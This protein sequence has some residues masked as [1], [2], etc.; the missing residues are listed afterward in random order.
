M[1]PSKAQAS[2]PCNRLRQETPSQH[3]EIDGACF[4]YA[5][6]HLRKLELQQIRE[7]YWEPN[8]TMLSNRQGRIGAA[9]RR[10]NSQRFHWYLCKGTA[11]LAVTMR[12][13]EVS[14]LGQQKSPWQPLP[15]RRLLSFLHSSTRAASPARGGLFVRHGVFPLWILS[16]GNFSCWLLVPC[17]LA[18]GLYLRTKPFWKG[19][20]PE[21]MS[22]SLCPTSKQGLAQGCSGFNR[23]LR[24]RPALQ[25]PQYNRRLRLQLQGHHTPS[26]AGSQVVHALKVRTCT[27]SARL[28]A[29]GARSA[30]TEHAPHLLPSGAAQQLKGHFSSPG[31][32]MEGLERLLRG[33]EKM[34]DIS[35]KTYVY[36]PMI[37]C[38]CTAPTTRRNH[39][40]ERLKQHLEHPAEPPPLSPQGPV[41]QIF[42]NPSG[43]KSPST[44]GILSLTTLPT[45]HCCTSSHD[46]GPLQDRGHSAYDAAIH[47]EP[48][49][50]KLTT[51]CTNASSPRINLYLRLAA[52]LF[53]T[54]IGLA[55]TLLLAGLSLKSSIC[56]S[57]G[58]R[59]VS[60][61]LLPH[62]TSRGGEAR[63]AKPCPLLCDITETVYNCCSVFSY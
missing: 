11:A 4:C 43:I 29:R 18:Q 55:L 51:C 25:P 42:R 3:K 14:Q 21:P 12:L 26:E 2:R 39:L 27:F 37:N 33:E 60:H 44:G 20:G 7:A 54:L 48:A 28:L 61:T 22:A 36:P 10:A 46:F 17:L 32:L 8:T 34:S 53:A 40:Q 56:S 23:T 59:L 50:S 58:D 63:D 45:A 19:A 35:S 13:Q 62:R 47:A 57:P 1:A 6:A 49:R 52:L 16:D 24:C 38:P 9:E 15:A 30:S 41:K 31:L 5:K